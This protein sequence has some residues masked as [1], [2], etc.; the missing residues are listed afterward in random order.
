MAWVSPAA[1]QGYRRPQAGSQQPV[2]TLP[3]PNHTHTM[4]AARAVLPLPNARLLTRASG[5]QVMQDMRGM[6]SSFFGRCSF[7]VNFCALHRTP[8]PLASYCAHMWRIC[9]AGE[10]LRTWRHRRCCS[11][12][13]APSPRR[14]RNGRC[15]SRSA[16]AESRLQQR[17]QWRPCSW[18]FPAWA[19][20][21]LY[22]VHTMLRCQGPSRL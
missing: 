16:R 7:A 18:D 6:I 14:G 12:H 13:R 9:P 10:H 1:L 11:L 21:A 17:L 4:P 3:T 22:Q 5:S 20:P 8:S 19:R 15:W 2:P